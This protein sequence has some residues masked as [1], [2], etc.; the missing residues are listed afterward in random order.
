MLLPSRVLYCVVGCC[1]ATVSCVLRS[2]GV[3]CLLFILIVESRWCDVRPGCAV[4]RR[5]I[6]GG[7]CELIAWRIAC[8][9]DC[10]FMSGV[11]KLLFHASC[12]VPSTVCHSP[13]F[14]ATLITTSI[15]PVL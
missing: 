15:Q 14:I 9:R 5:G 6:Y 2:N 12:A 3:L 13:R 4:L 11:A 1:A 7:V 10:C 8:L